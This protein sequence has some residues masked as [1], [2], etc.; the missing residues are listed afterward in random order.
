MEFRVEGLGFRVV[1]VRVQGFTVLEFR[2][3]RLWGLGF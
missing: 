2:V 3:L 1:G